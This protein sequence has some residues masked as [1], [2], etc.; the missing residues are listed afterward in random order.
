M[1]AKLYKPGDKVRLYPHDL[2]SV[3]KGA[4]LGCDIFFYD[5]G[6]ENTYTQA[7]WRQICSDGCVTIK[8]VTEFHGGEYH[9]EEMAQT[10]ADEIIHG[11]YFK[12][13]ETVLVTGNDRKEWVPRTFL[14][15]NFFSS[16]PYE[17]L[18][19]G[20]DFNKVSVF[21]NDHTVIWPYA[22]P[23]PKEHVV[24][25]YLKIDGKQVPDEILTKMSKEI[26][27]LLRKET[28]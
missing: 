21:C 8:S 17:C 1:T 4:G 18:V 7:M 19:E 10:V 22:K 28:L 12:P 11:Y 6:W 5:K 14:A 23:M 9:V 25:L 20:I 16:H 2:L 24:Q 15:M 26:A 3:L 13:G 27:N